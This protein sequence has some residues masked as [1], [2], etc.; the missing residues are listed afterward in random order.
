[1]VVSNTAVNYN[2]ILTLEKVVTAVI[3]RGIVC[4]SGPW[5]TVT[6]LVALVINVKV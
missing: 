5:G 4:N 1:V 3:Y 2:S 6:Q